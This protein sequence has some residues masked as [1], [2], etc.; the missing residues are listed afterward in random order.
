MDLDCT[1]ASDTDYGQAKWAAPVVTGV[2][3][4]G[5]PVGGG[6]NVMVTGTGFYGAIWVSFGP[7][8]TL[9]LKNFTVAGIPEGT[10]LSP[11]LSSGLMAGAERRLA[12][13]VAAILALIFH[14]G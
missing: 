2:I 9:P 11:D 5:G 10:E 1:V 4:S 6:D 12:P 8:P 13:F 7:P 3:P 14:P